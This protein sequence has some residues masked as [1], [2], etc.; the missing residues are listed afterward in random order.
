M[1]T[2]DT[3]NSVC[4]TLSS[5]CAFCPYCISGV[6]ECFIYV[7]LDDSLVCE[8]DCIVLFA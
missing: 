4:R 5:T 6:S 7:L 8:E 3:N 1:I 2:R